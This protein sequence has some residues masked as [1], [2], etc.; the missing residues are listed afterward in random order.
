[1]GKPKPNHDGPELTHVDGVPVKKPVIKK[2]FPRSLRRDL[3]DA[4]LVA[5]A[6]KMAAAQRAI[7]EANSELDDFKQRHKVDV[8][9]HEGVLEK[10]GNLIRTRYVH[11]QIKCEA[12]L[13]YEAE[14]YT[15][16][17]LDTG[18]I[19]EERAM[20]KTEL[21]ELALDDGGNAERKDDEGD[22]DDDEDN[23]NEEND[24]E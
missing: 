20:T 14:T 7:E 6:E 2:K 17:R 10:N 21:S 18:G 1:M 22:F 3:T 19:V 9:T 23:E 11:E 8:K 5:A 16:T 4:E 13:D 12:T 15:V 24:D